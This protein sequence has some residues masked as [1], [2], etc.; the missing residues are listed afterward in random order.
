[1]IYKSQ[2]LQLIK[3]MAYFVFL[4][5]FKIEHLNK[6]KFYIIIILSKLTNK[7]AFKAALR[8]E[9]Y[10]LGRYHLAPAYRV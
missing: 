8:M 2:T 6:L 5:Y 4:F 10:K 9:L 7:K 1:M 3:T